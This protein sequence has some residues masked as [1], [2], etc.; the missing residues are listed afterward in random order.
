MRYVILK[1]YKCG[2]NGSMVYS[3]FSRKEREDLS[4]LLSFFYF[5]KRFH[6]DIPVLNIT[7]VNTL[8]IKKKEYL[9]R[10][11]SKKIKFLW[12]YGEFLKSLLWVYFAQSQISFIFWILPILELVLCLGFFSWNINE[13]MPEILFK[14]ALGFICLCNAI[15]IPVFIVKNVSSIVL[16]MSIWS[17]IQGKGAMEPNVFY[18][19]NVSMNVLWKH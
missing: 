4:D 10:R 5:W 15:M 18:V 7:L 1:R 9:W 13:S 2:T 14:L 17:M 12:F 8:I 11:L 3:V 16:W 19:R 6:L